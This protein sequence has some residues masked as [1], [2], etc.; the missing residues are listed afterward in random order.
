M[1]TMAPSTRTE[2]CSPA[3]PKLATD[4]PRSTTRVATRRPCRVQPQPPLL[5]RLP[6]PEAKPVPA[7]FRL[8]D[9]SELR[10]PADITLA[11]SR[12]A[13]EIH[14]SSW[15]VRSGSGIASTK[16]RKALC[17]GG[18]STPILIATFGRAWVAVRTRRRTCSSPRSGT[19]CPKPCCSAVGKGRNERQPIGWRS[20]LLLVR[21]FATF[22]DGAHI[23]L[24]VCYL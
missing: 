2:F 20:F 3:L 21:S 16:D 14:G 22:R 5:L 11:D 23:G 7:A 6:R 8:G 1:R 12:I 19:T 15:R 13:T 9:R 17:N 18:R 24:D 4:Q 10:S